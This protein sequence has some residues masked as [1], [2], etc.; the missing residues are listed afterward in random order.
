MMCLVGF[1]WE[2]TKNMWRF[3]GKHTKYP[4]KMR[5][6]TPGYIIFDNDIYLNHNLQGAG[7]VLK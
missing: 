1:I 4:K 5:S 3:V 6:F 2:L 7:R